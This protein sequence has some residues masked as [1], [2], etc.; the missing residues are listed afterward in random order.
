MRYLDVIFL[1]IMLYKKF[2]HDFILGSYHEMHC[3]LKHQK[4]PLQVAWSQPKKGVNFGFTY[5]KHF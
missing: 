4:Y 5:E 1:Q 2:G 3:V